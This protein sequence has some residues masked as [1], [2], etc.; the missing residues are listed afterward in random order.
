MIFMTLASQWLPLPVFGYCEVRKWL[1]IQLAQWRLYL[2]PAALIFEI[3]A[4]CPLF[5]YEL[6]TIFRMYSDYVP[7]QHK[8]DVACGEGRMCV[9]WGRNWNFA[10]YLGYFLAL[11]YWLG[12]SCGVSME[13]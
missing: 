7:K 8:P 12:Q 11:K 2:P 3:S 10:N 4:F 1:V 13:L 6:P 9:V 5:L